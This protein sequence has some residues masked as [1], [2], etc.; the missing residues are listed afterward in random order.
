M[1]AGFRAGSGNAHQL[2]NRT[3]EDVVYLEIGDRPADDAVSYPDDDLQAV[4]HADGKWR[5]L[6]KDSASY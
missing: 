1:C 4:L 3:M 6:H 5:F 2:I